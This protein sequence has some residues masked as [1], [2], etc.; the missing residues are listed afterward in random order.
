MTLVSSLLSPGNVAHSKHPK[1][2]VDLSSSERLLQSMSTDITTS[3]GSSIDN[4]HRHWDCLFKGSYSDMRGYNIRQVY[5]V[6]AGFL[7]ALTLHGSLSLS[8]T[9]VADSLLF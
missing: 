6:F 1:P 5:V 4:A 7:S 2:S 8:H 3:V 9:S